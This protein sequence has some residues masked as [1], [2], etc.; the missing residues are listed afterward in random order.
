MGL[1]PLFPWNPLHQFLLYFQNRIIPASQTEPFANSLDMSIHCNSRYTKCVGY[2]N[3]RRFSPYTRKLD[4]LAMLTWY[5]SVILMNQNMT[6]VLDMLGFTAEQSD[7]AYVLLQFFQRD[8][9]I[10]FRSFI[11]L[12]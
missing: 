12:E 7:L 3:I 6:Q 5:F 1:C 8:G 4:K 10:V 11:F 9:D 2:N